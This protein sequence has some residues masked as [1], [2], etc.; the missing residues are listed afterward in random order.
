[1]GR[2]CRKGG[3]LGRL[4]GRAGQ[5]GGGLGGLGWPVGQGWVSGWA[6]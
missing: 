2:A 6:G 1:V 5:K 4:V 3:G